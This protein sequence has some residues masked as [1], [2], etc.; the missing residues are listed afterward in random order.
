M[1]C[2]GGPGSGGFGGPELGIRWATDTDRLE[3]DQYDG[4]K[5]EKRKETEAGQ[6]EVEICQL[7]GGEPKRWGAPVTGV[8]NALSSS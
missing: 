5:R 8:G 2:R 6:K 7:G 4:N 3:I 1:R